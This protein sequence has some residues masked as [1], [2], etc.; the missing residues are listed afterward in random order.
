MTLLWLFRVFVGFLP[1][2]LRSW[3]ERRQV[4]RELRGFWGGTERPELW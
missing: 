1:E 4:E 3:R 2:L